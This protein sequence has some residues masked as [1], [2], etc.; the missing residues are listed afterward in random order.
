[1]HISK[2]GA[3]LLKAFLMSLILPLVM[4]FFITLIN[5]GFQSSFLFIWI[6]NYVIAVVI[7]F[8]LIILISPKIN[9]FVERISK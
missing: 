2:K 5:V 4:I 7:A 1:M 9:R 3:P 8:P 6:K